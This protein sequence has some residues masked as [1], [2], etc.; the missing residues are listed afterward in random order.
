MSTRDQAVRGQA[1]R[2]HLREEP[3][4][5][6]GPGTWFVALVTILALWI[7]ALGSVYLYEGTYAGRIYLGVK[8]AGIDLAAYTPSEARSVLLANYGQY[9]LRPLVLRHGDKEWQVSP[10]ELGVQF[11]VSETVRSA[12]NVGRE[13]GLMAGL[14]AQLAAFR[15]GIEVQPPAVTLQDTA[16][17]AFLTNLEP[18]INQPLREPQVTLGSD[19]TVAVTT[20][21]PGHK[22]DIDKTIEKIQN[23][24]RALSS[25]PID[26]VVNDVGPTTA[27]ADLAAL[28]EMAEKSLAQP[29]QARYQDKTWTLERTD[30][31]KLLVFKLP[32]GASEQPR[33]TL[34]RS[35]LESWLTD[36]AKEINRDPRDARFG[37]NGPGQLS[38]IR[39]SEEGRKLEVAKALDAFEAQLMSDNR[40]V[41]LPVTVIKPKVSDSDAAALNIRELVM[42]ASTVYG[43]GIPQ[44]LHNVELAASLLNGVVVL[45]GEV[46]SFNDE[47]GPATLEAGFQTGYGI[48]AN[49]QGQLATVPTV[50]GGI[51]QVATTLF[52]AVFWAGYTIE[53]RHWHSYWIP[54]YGQPPR[55]LQGLDATVD[56]Q[57]DAEGKRIIGGLDFKFRNSGGDPLLIVAR[58]DGATLYFDLYG[59]KPAWEV[60]V[61]GPYITDV[62]KPNTETIR[63]EDPNLPEGQTLVLEQAGDGFT[64]TIVR[65]VTLQGQLVEKQEFVAKYEPSHNVIA[66]G[67]KKPGQ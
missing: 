46:F 25:A 28:K 1:M 14:R 65:T 21:Q 6:K 52:H 54:R 27:E 35:K 11:D 24:V 10:A 58:T 38:I 51:C 43:P 19:L 7:L 30:L 17:R 5:G 22:L 29:L 39:H 44:R 23:Q 63:Q 45:P 13:G 48:Y 50:A 64:S 59:V 15:H 49:G 60:K 47:L 37:W 3:K 4:A 56:Q 31:A 2:F 9:A 33:L 55:G 61:D 36:R 66:V 53:E 12:Y 42:E 40:V 57:L 62:V 26:L 20:S 67:T 8:S 41:D 32:T 34:D 16:A 18:Q